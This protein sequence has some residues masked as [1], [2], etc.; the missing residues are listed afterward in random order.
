MAG[1]AGYAGFES[2][3]TPLNV[4]SGRFTLVSKSGM[5][6]IRQRKTTMIDDYLAQAHRNKIQRY[7][8]LLQTTLTKFERQFVEKR[9]S[10]EQSKLEMLVRSL[11]SKVNRDQST[12]PDNL[13]AR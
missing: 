8:L 13:L 6:G 3:D 9:L 4:A 12:G 1:P 2:E 11:S 5:V 10:E 7:R